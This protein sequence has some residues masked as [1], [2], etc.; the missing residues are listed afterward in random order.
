MDKSAI[1]VIVRGKVQGVFFRA[2][3]Q[4]TAE[5][6]G[7][8][9]WVRNRPDGNVEIQAEGDRARLEKLVAWCHDGPPSAKVEGVEV[10]WIPPD[11]LRSFEVLR[12]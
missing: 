2:S 8:A 10:E 4:E 9:G 5:G 12:M 3:T 6:L 11:G 7:L 1:H